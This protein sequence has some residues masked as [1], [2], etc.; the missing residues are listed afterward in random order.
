MMR[1]LLAAT[2]A[3]CAAALPASAASTRDFDAQLH[4]NLACSTGFDLCGKGLVQGFGTVTTALRFTG[5]GPGPGNCA[6]V[7]AERVIT[8]DSDGSTLDMALDGVL[9]PKGSPNGHPSGSGTF[10]I[11]G[12]T[13]VF[14]GAT[15]SGLL[16]VQSTGTPV[17][18]DT[19]HYH[20][21]I[22]LP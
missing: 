12:G 4:D 13:G 11:T 6:G 22:T 10:T 16:S 8:L 21:T 20:G 7:T 3:A 5:F 19:A 17:P 9:C 2:I 1:V 15:G 18:S 14:A